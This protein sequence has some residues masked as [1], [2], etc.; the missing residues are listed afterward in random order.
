MREENVMELDPLLKPAMKLLFK[1]KSDFEKNARA[2]GLSEESI[3]YG[4]QQCYGYR[5]CK[6]IPRYQVLGH[7]IKL[8]SGY[9]R[10][11]HN[12]PL[13]GKAREKINR[14]VSESHFNSNRRE[15]L[16]HF[17]EELYRWKR[18][19]ESL[20]CEQLQAYDCIYWDFS[21]N[22][23]NGLIPLPIVLLGR[24]ASDH[25]PTRKDEAAFRRDILEKIENSDLREF[26]KNSYVMSE[27]GKEYLLKRGLSEQWV[28]ALKNILDSIHYRNR[29][30]TKYRV[31][32]D[33]L[34]RKGIIVKGVNYST[35]GR[36]NYYRVEL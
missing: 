9:G 21:S 22:V 35:R 14:I 2:Y 16:R 6:P 33:Y 19:L 11:L 5:T 29:S 26:V 27:S 1:G 8:Q 32:M 20:T 15:K 18:Y 4:L 23:L 34:I 28:K 12:A 31:L 25:L 7:I 13:P 30:A 36:C 3:H 17:L 24:W 10:E